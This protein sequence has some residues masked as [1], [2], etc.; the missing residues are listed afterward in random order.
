[1]CENGSV[2][3]NEREIKKKVKVAIIELRFDEISQVNGYIS[4]F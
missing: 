1:M 2:Y 3:K 4:K